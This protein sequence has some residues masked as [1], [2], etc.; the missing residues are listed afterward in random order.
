[1]GRNQ[2]GMR[3]IENW[4]NIGRR[5]ER[6]N[7]SVRLSNSNI[8]KKLHNIFLETCSTHCLRGPELLRIGIMFSGRVFDKEMLYCVR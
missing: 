4:W 7:N 3:V 2:F 8:I 1:M 6:N 5:W